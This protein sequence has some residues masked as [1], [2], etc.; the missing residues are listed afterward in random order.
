MENK[1][2][3]DEVKHE[4]FLN[5]S[6]LPSVTKILQG[7]GV[8]DLSGIPLDKLEVA[9]QRGIDVHSACELYD[10]DNLQEGYSN[11][12]LDA[13]IEFRRDT[14]FMPLE[15]EKPVYSTRYRFAGT[16]DRVGMLNKLT[17]VDIKTSE[18]L[19]P[20]TAL[21]TSG[22]ELAYNEFNDNK[23]KERVA[24]LLTAEGK[25]KIEPYRDKNDTNV[26][27]AALSIFNWKKGNL[28]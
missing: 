3:F 19:S 10:L 7:A 20:A 18:D 13:W 25:Y 22:Y 26:F 2:V 1:L 23:V 15:I 17:I 8:I 11:P 16:P 27:L 5:G 9:R 12:Y 24:V 14:G 4:Y 28:K 21:Q 6:K